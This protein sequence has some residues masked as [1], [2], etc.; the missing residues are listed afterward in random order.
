MRPV[1]RWPPFPAMLAALAACALPLPAMAGVGTAEAI[2]ATTTRTLLGLLLPVLLAAVVGAL[3][4]ASRDRAGRAFAAG[5]AAAVAA[6]AVLRWLLSPHAFLH[7]YYHHPQFIAAQFGGAGF[8]TIY[9]ETGPTL[10]RIAAALSGADEAVVFATNALLATATIAATAWAALALTGR[11][12]AALLAA[13]VLALLPAHLR[14]SA[15]EDPVIPAACFGML[16]LAFAL[17]AIDTGRWWALA[18]TV[19]TLALA[20]HA[21]P[22]MLAWTAALPGLLLLAR[23]RAAARAWATPPFLAAIAALALLLAPRLLALAAGWDDVLAMRAS[24][25]PDPSGTPMWLRALTDPAAHLALRGDATPR[26]VPLLAAAGAAWLALRRPGA[27]AA[28]A[29]PAIGLVALTPAGYDNPQ[30]VA[31]SQVLVQPFW[32]I[33]AGAA[34]PALA[35][36]AGA[37]WRRWRGGRP[38]APLQPAVPVALGLGLAVLPPLGLMPRVGT[39]AAIPE[40]HQE[41]RF[42]RDAIP[43]LPRGARVIATRTPSA[44]ALD[45]FPTW[46][47]RRLGREDVRVVDLEDAIATAARGGP[48]LPPA[49][50]DLLFY[51]GMHCH[52][53]F[54]DEPPPEPL[55]PRCLAVRDRYVLAPLAEADLR[56][57]PS[58]H[59]RYAGGPDGPWRVGFHR[60]I[61]DRGGPGTATPAPSG[62][63]EP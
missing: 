11:R 6:G 28:L 33:V 57:P 60:V 38:G 5:V 39:V 46:L 37:A 63:D 62:T 45:A 21:R 19:A 40:S 1:R 27:L 14:H 22:E 32:A 10:H 3:R 20:A 56:G 4:D 2:T 34:L 47:L 44:R 8:Q 52:F 42:L 26:F 59:L 16:S 58:S 13:W 55:H 61:G 30:A 31:R 24:G 51:Q 36:V 7:E 48:G 15:A 23:G 25:P 49:A 54:E 43:L 29:V 35:D 18:G 17:R 12:S 9:G 53:A 41:W 50:P